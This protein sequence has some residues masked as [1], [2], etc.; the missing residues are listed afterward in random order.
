MEPKIYLLFSRPTGGFGP[1]LITCAFSGDAKG[2]LGL[3]R[4]F[5][6]LR[7]LAATLETAGVSEYQMQMPI[8]VIR[9]GMPSFLEVTVETAEKLGLLQRAIS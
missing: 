8:Q 5:A 6:Q 3:S 1:T 9:N 2:L 7:E 4:Q